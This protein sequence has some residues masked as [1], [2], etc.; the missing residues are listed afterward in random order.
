MGKNSISIL[1]ITLV[2]SM[3]GCSSYKPALVEDRVISNPTVGWSG[4]SVE[5]PAGMEVVYPYN[6]AVA[7]GHSG[8][9]R[10]WCERQFDGFQVD[11]DATFSETFLM[12]KSGHKFLIGFSCAS[13]SMPFSW[14]TMPNVTRQYM[15]RKMMNDK[16]VLINDSNALSEQVEMNGRHGWHISGN[17]H[18]YSGKDT[19]VMAYEGYFILGSMKEVY[20]IESFGD[21]SERAVMD[22]MVKSM[23]KSLD[24][25]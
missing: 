6:T 9:F 20:W 2:F 18:S 10:H 22:E 8:I 3:M 19:I 12:E 1:M 4:Y 5:I 15:L 13:Y 16:I 21:T 24:V 23:V 14:S 11:L 17:S 7:S 25:K